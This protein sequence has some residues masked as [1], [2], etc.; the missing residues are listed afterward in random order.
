MTNKKPLSVKQ[1]IPMFL[2]RYEECHGSKYNVNWSMIKAAERV[3][4]YYSVSDIS[5]A[6]DKYFNSKKEHNIWDFIDNINVYLDMA[7]KQ[8]EA[9]ERL[10][11][12]LDATKKKME[13]IE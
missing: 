2:D 4:A 11:R 1:I 3:A 7:R 8:K 13:E 9:E 6:M 5:T 12:L 10:K